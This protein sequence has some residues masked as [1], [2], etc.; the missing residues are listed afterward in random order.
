MRVPWQHI[1]PPA[2][3]RDRW[4]A[5]LTGLR[6]SNSEDISAEGRLCVSDLKMK[7]KLDLTSRARRRSHNLSACQPYVWGSAGQSNVRLVSR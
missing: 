3:R 2:G 5:N 4:L 7:D 6:P 1:S